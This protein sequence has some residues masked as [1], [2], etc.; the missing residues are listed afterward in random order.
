MKRNEIGDNLQLIDKICEICFNVIVIFATNR[1]YRIST[2][3]GL[4]GGTVYLYYEAGLW[5]GTDETI[6][7]YAKLQKDVNALYEANPDV[8]KW[9]EYISSS[10]SSNVK[11]YTEVK[12]KLN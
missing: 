10:V 4:A 8:K 5:R 11:P 12:A 9:V 3:A 7:N 1:Y 2:K 6:E